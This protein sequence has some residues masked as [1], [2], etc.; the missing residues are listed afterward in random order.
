M[1][2]HALCHGHGLA[3]C[4]ACLRL[5][6][7]HPAAAANP[8]QAWIEPSTRDNRCAAWRHAPPQVT[9]ATTKEPRP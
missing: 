4:N 9:P 5:A 1:T 6:D 3:L 2:P 8:R 7:R